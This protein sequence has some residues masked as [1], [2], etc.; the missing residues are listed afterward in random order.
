MNAARKA[1]GEKRD[2]QRVFRVNED[3]YEEISTLAKFYGYGNPTEFIRRA[4]R[5][6]LDLLHTMETREK[7]RRGYEEMAGINLEWSRV[8][9]SADTKILD[10][11]EDNLS[12]CE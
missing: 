11:Y 5:Q 4:M 7:M 3:E 8:G 10:K 12:E 1:L 6:S 9:L 2:K